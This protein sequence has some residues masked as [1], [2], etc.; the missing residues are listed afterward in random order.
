MAEG[1]IKSPFLF[2]VRNLASFNG[3]NEKVEG[4]AEIYFNRW[5]DRSLWGKFED[6]G[7]PGAHSAETRTKAPTLVFRLILVKFRPISDPILKKI[8]TKSDY[9]GSKIGVFSCKK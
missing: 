2:I 7:L 5:Y 3:K 8:Q 4:S 9:F 6:P 1:D